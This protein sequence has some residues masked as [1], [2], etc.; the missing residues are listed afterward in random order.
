[1]VFLWPQ[2][3]DAQLREI[4]RPDYHLR[5]GIG[6]DEEE[7]LR[8]MKRQTFKRQLD[9]LS[10]SVA[11]GRVLDVGCATGFFLE[12]ATEAGWNAYGVE[13]SGFAAELAQRRFGDR[14]FNGTLE[15][16]TYPDAFFDLVML[17]D[18]IEHVPDPRSFLYEVRRVLRPD[19]VVMLVTPNSVSLS[20]RLMERHWS[21][22]NPEHL[23]YFSPATIIRLLSM[24][25]FMVEC[26]EDFPKDL[27][28]NYIGAQLEKNPRLFMAGI[29]RLAGA[30]VPVCLKEWNFSVHCGEMMVLARKSIKFSGERV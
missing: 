27:N 7:G 21:H 6:G 24:C 1:M 11:S 5:W 3:D 12:V 16:A 13:L 10:G 23:H 25:G 2:P 17:S 14:V 22:Y 20:A 4:Y 8:A 9:R 30:V 19:G 26:Q 28:L 29:C 18:I 15:Q